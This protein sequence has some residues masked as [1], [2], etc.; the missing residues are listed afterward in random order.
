MKKYLLLP[1]LLVFLASCASTQNTQTATI[2]KAEILDFGELNLTGL[3]TYDTDTTAAGK[4]DLGNVQS[5]N[6]RTT[7]IMAEKDKTFGV[8]FKAIGEPEGGSA[9]LTIRAI[10][11][12]INGKTVSSAETSVNE[13]YRRSA[14]YTFSQPD[15]LLSGKWTIQILDK[16]RVL[17]E[18]TFNVKANRYSVLGS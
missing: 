1:L 13:G 2:A 4:F 16:D 3:E 7:N 10:H 17:A 15:E 5:V 18:K 14:F 9:L 11:P 12:P 8:I 6:K